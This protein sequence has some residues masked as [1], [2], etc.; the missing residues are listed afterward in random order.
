MKPSEIIIK[1]AFVI[2]NGDKAT[3]GRPANWAD[4]VKAILDYLDETSL[5]TGGKA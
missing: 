2:A 4:Y 1:K 5:S 3:S